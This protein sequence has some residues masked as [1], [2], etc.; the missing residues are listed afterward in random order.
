MAD[1]MNIRKKIFF[2]LLVIIYN[3]SSY[4]P[5]KYDLG[6]Y[7]KKYHSFDIEVYLREETQNNKVKIVG[8]IRNIYIY[9]MANFEITARVFVDDNKIKEKTY[10]FFPEVLKP[11]DYYPF[12]IDL[13]EIPQN[14]KISYFYRYNTNYD[15]DFSL[16]YG[17]F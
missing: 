12:S 8:L 11:N 5:I 13:D 4:V 7:N 15:E 14:G 10:Y 6:L 17:S 9:D 2:L 1:F 3:C 16:Q